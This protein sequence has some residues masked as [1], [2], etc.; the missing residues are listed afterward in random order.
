MV[1]EKSFLLP[2]RRTEVVAAMQKMGLDPA[3]ETLVGNVAK[4]LEI[5]R[6]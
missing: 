1:D 3:D 2:E 6:A 5:M 4:R